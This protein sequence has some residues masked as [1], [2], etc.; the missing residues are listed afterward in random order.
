MDL[1]L[2][3]AIGRRIR[4]RPD[5]IDRAIKVKYLSN[6]EK[7]R[8]INHFIELTFSNL[9]HRFYVKYIPIRRRRA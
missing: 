7:Q 5:K 2:S 8:Q 4:I 9:F 3:N 1:P 6:K